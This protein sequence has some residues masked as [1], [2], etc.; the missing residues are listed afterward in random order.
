MM[1]LCVYN[2]AM[3]KLFMSYMKTTFYQ[4]FPVSAAYTKLF[5][6]PY[7]MC[8]MLSECTMLEPDV[9]RNVICFDEPYYMC[10]QFFSLMLSLSNPQILFQMLLNA[11]HCKVLLFC[12]R[13]KYVHFIPFC[14]LETVTGTGLMSN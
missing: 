7:V 8:V 4:M 14:F 2:I 6:K 3:Q 1:I 10:L 5:T 13:L 11:L 12:M 9:S